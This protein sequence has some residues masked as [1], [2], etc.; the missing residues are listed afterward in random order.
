MTRVISASQRRK[1]HSPELHVR[2]PIDGLAPQPLWGAEHHRSCLDS[3]LHSPEIKNQTELWLCDLKK[4]RIK[5]PAQLKVLSPFVAEVRG[6]PFWWEKCHLTFSSPRSQ[7]LGLLKE[8]VYVSLCVDIFICVCICESMCVHVSVCVCVYICMHAHTSVLVSM[9]L[10]VY[11]HVYGC[12]LWMSYALYMYMC[13]C[14]CTE[15]HALMCICT[16]VHLWWCVSL[17][18][19]I[20]VCIHVSVCIF[21]CARISVCIHLSLCMLYVCLCVHMYAYIY[22]CMSVCMCIHV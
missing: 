12:I 8:C 18:L 14:D 16:C 2:C 20:Y 21:I 6:P 1:E 3:S 7:N 5:T 15:R 11:I 22:G 4:D 10:Y 13:M 19:S 17:C 9:C